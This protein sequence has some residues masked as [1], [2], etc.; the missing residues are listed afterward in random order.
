MYMGSRNSRTASCAFSV[1][2]DGTGFWAEIRFPGLCPGL[3]TTR[4]HR[5]VTF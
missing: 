5:V 2:P 3:L 1:V 4:L